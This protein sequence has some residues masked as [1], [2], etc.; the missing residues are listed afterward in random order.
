M[1]K[2]TPHI[3]ISP[4]LIVLLSLIIFPLIFSLSMSFT[5]F[6]FVFPKFKF[7][8]LKNYAKI[9]TS[10]EFYNSLRLSVIFSFS[11]TL[12][13]LLI[14]LGT[15][16][17]LNRRF[18]GKK[19]ITTLL[20]VPMTV[21]PVA[22]GIMWLL[23]YQ[24]DFG[25]IN[26]LL[27]L[28]GIQ[29]PRWTHRAETALIAVIITDIW[30]WTPF[31]TLILLSGMVHLPEEPFEAAKVDGAS[32]L[33]SFYYITL[34]LLLPVILIG[35]LLRLIDA[36]RV[37]DLIYVMTEG[38]PGMCTEVLSLSIYRTGLIHKSLGYASSMSY[39]FLA[40]LL[41]ITTLLIKLMRRT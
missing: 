34:P 20:I 37:F 14:G 9:L 18:F 8:G 17:V 35:L 4:V 26:Y 29:G 19:V 5:N 16:T 2:F 24:P 41:M 32:A 15:A 39:I 40:I 30:Q 25:I 1:S 6:S 13:S 23:L 33:Q 27:S 38:G 36:F 28:I 3:L 12:I 21:T 10:P 7:I 11:S 22:T 31:F